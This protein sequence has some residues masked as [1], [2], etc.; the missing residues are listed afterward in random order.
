M[1]LRSGYHQQQSYTEPGLRLLSENSAVF[2]MALPF[3]HFNINLMVLVLGSLIWAWVS[4][5]PSYL[6][7]L[8]EH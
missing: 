1:G 5:E 2:S 7:P 8:M 4:T 6:M 3:S